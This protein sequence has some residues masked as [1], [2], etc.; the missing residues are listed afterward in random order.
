MFVASIVS[1]HGIKIEAFE[2][3]SVIV[4]MV[5]YVLERGSLTMNSMAP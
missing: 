1:L 2:K 4:S 3:V 5:S